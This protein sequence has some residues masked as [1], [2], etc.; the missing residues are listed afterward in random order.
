MSGL[1]HADVLEIGAGTSQLDAKE[2][3]DRLKQAYGIFFAQQ[4][5]Q[6]GRFGV[7]QQAENPN[8]IF[9]GTDGDDVDYLDGYDQQVLAAQDRPVFV[10]HPDK[11]KRQQV[12]ARAIAPE[13]AA[14]VTAVPAPVPVVEVKTI[15]VSGRVPGEYTTS[16]TTVTVTPTAEDSPRRPRR[17]RR[18]VI[19]PTRVMPIDRTAPPLPEQQQQRKSGLSE[20]DAVED[21]LSSLRS[22]EAE[23]AGSFQDSRDGRTTFKT[24]TVT[25]T[26]CHMP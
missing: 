16:L 13:A 11:E 23:E 3:L 17:A 12:T 15:Y 5:Q 18:D 14:A 2:K 24:V 4:Q 20:E 6:Q 7:R 10:S 21:L 25:V 8:P 9:A 1:E 26:T 19:S 22:M